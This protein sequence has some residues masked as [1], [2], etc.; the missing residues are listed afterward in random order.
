MIQAARFKKEGDD[1]TSVEGKKQGFNPP[2]SQ[3]SA[4]QYRLSQ[5][6]RV[7]NVIWVSGQV[8]IDAEQNIPAGI[9]AQTRLAFE[10]MKSVFAAAGASMADIVDL[11]IFTTDMGFEM[12]HFGPIKDE[13]IP[14]PYPAVTGVEIS[15]LAHPD[16][17][18]ELKAVAIIGS[19]TT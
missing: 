11:T 12:K 14:A 15:R 4:E 18:I 6:M 7:G 1:V 2:A 16:L 13:F 19:G 9:A 5:A 10:N 17:L 8:G 3:A